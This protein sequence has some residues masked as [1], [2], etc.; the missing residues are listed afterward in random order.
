MILKWKRR[1]CKLE[2]LEKMMF[3]EDDV[4]VTSTA[5]CVRIINTAYRAQICFVAQLSPFYKHKTQIHFLKQRNVIAE[6]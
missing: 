2:A 3:G 5:Y 4:I 1:W 6:N